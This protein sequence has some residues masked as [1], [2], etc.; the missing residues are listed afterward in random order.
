MLK[1]REIPAQSIPI[2]TQCK[3]LLEPYILLVEFE[4]I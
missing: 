4:I 2:D 1:N 3:L